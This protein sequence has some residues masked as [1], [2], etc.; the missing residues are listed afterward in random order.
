M[1]FEP[2]V[3]KK[4]LHLTP[5]KPG[6][7]RKPLSPVLKSLNSF[8]TDSFNCSEPE[9]VWVCLYRAAGLCRALEGRPEVL[10]DL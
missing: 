1:R 7:G 4:A 9:R 2:V 6:R 8:P 3:I 5:R 10:P